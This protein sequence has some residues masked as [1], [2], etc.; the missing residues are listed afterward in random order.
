MCI[1]S[2]LGQIIEFVFLWHGLSLSV[3]CSKGG[4]NCFVPSKVDFVWTFLME[5]LKESVSE[6]RLQMCKSRNVLH[7]A[8]QMRW[9]MRGR[10]LSST[11]LQDEALVSTLL[12]LN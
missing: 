10:G 8:L 7:C 1:E 4:F 5:T 3:F 2:N 9:G 12:L 11:T 6:R